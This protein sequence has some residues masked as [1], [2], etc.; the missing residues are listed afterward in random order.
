M[1]D[2]QLVVPEVAKPRGRFYFQIVAVT[3]VVAL[4]ALFA[5]SLQLSAAGQLHAGSAPDF[6][7]T[8]FDGKQYRVAT[9]RQC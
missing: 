5:A 1:T 6:T 8:Q 3:V 9:K 2:A 4:V 7:F